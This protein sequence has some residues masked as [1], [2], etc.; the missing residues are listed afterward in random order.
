MLNIK[1]IAANGNKFFFMIIVL[2]IQADGI[3][4]IQNRIILSIEKIMSGHRVISA[5]AP[6][7]ATADPF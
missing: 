1:T 4:L 2:D 7:M 3:I 6:W 5:A